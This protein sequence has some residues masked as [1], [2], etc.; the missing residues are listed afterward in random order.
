[1]ALIGK[2]IAWILR[3]ILTIAAIT[4][5]LCL[6]PQNK[7]LENDSP[8]VW[9]IIRNVPFVALGVVIVCLFFQTR[10]EIGTFRPV[11]LLVAL[12]FLFYIPVAVFAPLLP[13]LGMLMLPKTVCYILM[14][15]SFIRLSRAGSHL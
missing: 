4:V 10:K 6:L 14:L 13:I 3:N 8:V 1:M 12:S 11:W 15:I 5:I 9:G 7:W 2:I